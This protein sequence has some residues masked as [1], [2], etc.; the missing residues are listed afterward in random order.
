MNQNY[1][2][3]TGCQIGPPVDREYTGLVKFAFLVKSGK[4][5]S[6]LNICST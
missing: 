2:S 1:L 6:M 4:L 5:F 3:I